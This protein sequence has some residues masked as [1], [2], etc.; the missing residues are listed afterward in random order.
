METIDQILMFRGSA[1]SWHIEMSRYVSVCARWYVSTSG[2][3]FAFFQVQLSEDNNKYP[4]IWSKNKIEIHLPFPQQESEKA[5]M[6]DL[7]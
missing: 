7:H 5:G 4:W 6:Q 3:L 1:D 2:P